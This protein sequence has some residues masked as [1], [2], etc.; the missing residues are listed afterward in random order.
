[1]VQLCLVRR[2]AS[3]WRRWSC[4]LL[5]SFVN[6]LLI[7]WEMDEQ[8]LPADLFAFHCWWDL[9]SY[10]SSLH[11]IVSPYS[12]LMEKLLWLLV[13]PSY[14][15][16]LFQFFHLFFE[17]KTQKSNIAQ[18]HWKRHMKEEASE[19]WICLMLNEEQKT[20]YLLT[21]YLMLSLA[22]WLESSQWCRR[23]WWPAEGLHYISVTFSFVLALVPQAASVKVPVV[24]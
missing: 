20:G 2:N 9:P 10:L 4:H 21:V 24:L 5:V 7:H 16:V 19:V 15:S 6:S 14:V 3:L 17:L 23:K 12:W 13:I 8:L 11:I 1:M 18:R 22:G